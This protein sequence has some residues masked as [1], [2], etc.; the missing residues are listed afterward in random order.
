M[1]DGPHKS[2]KMSLAWQRVAERADNGA[3]ECEEI[4]KALIPRLLSRTAG[5][6]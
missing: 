5:L 1:S 6:R 2:L 3:F 4:S